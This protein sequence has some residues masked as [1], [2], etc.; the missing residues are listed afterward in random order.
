MADRSGCGKW[1]GVHQDRPT[2]A[3]LRSGLE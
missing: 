2:P 1:G 3:D